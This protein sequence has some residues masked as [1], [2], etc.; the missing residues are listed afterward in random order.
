MQ[1]LLICMAASFGASAALAQNLPSP[2]FNNV[3]VNGAI[4]AP[5]LPNLSSSVEGTGT[6]GLDG[7][8]WMIFHA[9]STVADAS[10]A[11]LR[12]Q[13]SASYPNSGETGT[14]KAIWGLGYTSARWLV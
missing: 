4:K 8:H 2:V 7:A 12:V 1:K 11:S 13:R 5:E 6:P 9:P 10:N 14:A 3:T